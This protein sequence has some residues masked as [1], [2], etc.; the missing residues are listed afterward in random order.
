MFYP[1]NNRFFGCCSSDEVNDF[2]SESSGLVTLNNQR[3]PSRQNS[4]KSYHSL[5]GGNQLGN[6]VSLSRQNSVCSHYSAA[7][8]GGAVSR[9]NSFCHSR[10]NSV[11]FRPARL[12][13]R[14]S[15]GS[16]SLEEYRHNNLAADAKPLGG[17]RDWLYDNGTTEINADREDLEPVGVFMLF[18]VNERKFCPT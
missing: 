7:S 8:A 5:G 15:L 14:N 12:S 18:S 17:T 9:Q 11:S 2:Y 13:P 16:A 1:K 4:V 6:N 3:V 10:Q